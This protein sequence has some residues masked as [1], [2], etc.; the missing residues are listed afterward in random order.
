[1]EKYLRGDYAVPRG[2]LDPRERG[3][4]IGAGSYGM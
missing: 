1:M 2:N 3:V 4:G